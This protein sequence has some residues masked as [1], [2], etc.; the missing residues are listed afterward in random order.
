MQIQVSPIPASNILLSAI[1]D[2]AVRLADADV[3]PLTLNTAQIISS[4]FSLS[5]QAGARICTAIQHLHSTAS[6]NNLLYFGVG[7]HHVVRRLAK[8][9]DGIACLA[10][11]GCIAEVFTP[12]TAAIILDELAMLYIKTENRPSQLEWTKLVQACQGV[13]TFTDFGWWAEHFMDL[14]RDAINPVN[15][16]IS[17][18]GMGDPKDIAKALCGISSL[19]KSS[20]DSMTI[21]GGSTCGWLAAVAFWFMGLT[22]DI[23]HPSRENNP[24]IFQGDCQDS[25][26]RLIVEYSWHFFPGSANI[27]SQTLEFH[28]IKQIVS[29][30]PCH[31][32]LPAGRFKWDGALRGTFGRAGKIFLEAAAT[33]HFLGSMA[34]IFAAYARVED[35]VRTELER[36]QGWVGY[37]DSSYGYGFVSFG[38][39]QFP[40]LEKSDKKNL[41]LEYAEKTL[42]NALQNLA[43]A[44]RDLAILCECERCSKSSK[45]KTTFCLPI[46]AKVLT[47]LIWSLSLVKF[48]VMDEEGMP[49]DPNRQGL[50]EFYHYHA[51]LL[52]PKPPMNSLGKVSLFHRLFNLNLANISRLL[53]TGCQCLHKFYHFIASFFSTLHLPLNHGPTGLETEHLHPLL[54]LLN[55]PQLFA[56]AEFVFAGGLSDPSPQP[57]RLASVSGCVC[58]YLDI[59]CDPETN[60]STPGKQIRNAP[61]LHIVPGGIQLQSG[62]KCEGE[63]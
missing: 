35:E 61:I 25:R 27:E 62:R 10:L 43:W 5:P 3:Q 16:G 47:L 14:N 37:R 44:R 1:K 4:N 19:T 41:M 12:E 34:R 39:H 48:D 29:S 59:L 24:S 8:E 36:L 55:T 50:E 42:E 17:D 57:G 22:I 32:D 11:C 20:A 30:Q 40:E 23:R 26:G 60:T 9:K 33:Y 45:K 31:N 53:T 2:I 6:V 52:A 58:F 46:L 54:S 51:N 28:N 49:M 38:R 56:T 13:L 21:A 7:V 63:R 15:D 18:R